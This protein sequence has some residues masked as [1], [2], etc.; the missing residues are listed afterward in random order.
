MTALKTNPSHLMR[1]LNS[2]IVCRTGLGLIRMPCLPLKQESDG[3]CFHNLRRNKR[4]FLPNL[5]FERVL[6][7]PLTSLRWRVFSPYGCVHILARFVLTAGIESLNTVL[8]FPEILQGVQG[9]GRL[10]IAR[11]NRVSLLCVNGRFCSCISCN[12]DRFQKHDF[13]PCGTLTKGVFDYISGKVWSWRNY[14]KLCSKYNKLTLMGWKVL[15]FTGTAIKSGVALKT[16]EAALSIDWG[17]ATWRVT[18]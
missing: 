11:S 13:Y 3:R 8:S 16:I 15:R 18:A 7:S 2:C 17:T 9:D 1:V 12:K 10:A 4:I 6:P 5:S 14:I